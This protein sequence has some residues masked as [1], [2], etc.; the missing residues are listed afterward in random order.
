MEPKLGLATTLDADRLLRMMRAL[1]T[2]TR[3]RKTYAAPT[4]LRSLLDADLGRRAQKASA[5]PQAVLC[6]AFS[7]PQLGVNATTGVQ[8]NCLIASQRRNQKLQDL[9]IYL[10]LNHARL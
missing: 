10:D 1:L 2:C 9:A 3:M 6:R 4:A 8:R 5:L 7:A